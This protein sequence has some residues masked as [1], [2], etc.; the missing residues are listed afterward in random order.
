MQSHLAVGGTAKRD[1]VADLHLIPIDEHAVDEQFGELAA[2]REGRP[3]QSLG[4]ASA[5]C[6]HMGGEDGDLRLVRRTRRELL[7]FAGEVGEPRVQGARARPQLV[8]RERFR[9]VRVDEPLTLAVERRAPL[10]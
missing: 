5:E 10:V 3:V 2:A 9:S 8:E 7:L 1:D 4:D 6:L